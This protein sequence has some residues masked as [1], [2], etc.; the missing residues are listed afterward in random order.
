MTRQEG[1]K[2]ITPHSDHDKARQAVLIYNSRKTP[3]GHWYVLLHS[4][5]VVIINQQWSFV[6]F[7]SVE[8]VASL[9]SAFVLI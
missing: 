7:F 9:L 6:F 4:V 8:I 5:K 2:T 3:L 1:T